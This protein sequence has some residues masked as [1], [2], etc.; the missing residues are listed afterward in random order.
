VRPPLNRRQVLRLGATIGLTALPGRAAP[1]AVPTGG[2][3]TEMARLAR[4]FL[5]EQGLPGL[6]VAFGREG[7][8]LHADG[9]G[10]ADAAGKV[11]V[12]PDH[13]F[14]IASVSK[15]ITATAI[16]VCVQQGRLKLD[17]PV[18]GPRGVLDFPATEALHG[19]TVDHLLTHT[20]GGWPNDGTD[21]MFRDPKLTHA[22]LIPW[23]LANLKPTHAPGEKY[24]YSNFGYCLLGRV[25]EKVTGQPYAEAVARLVLAP[26]GITGMHL[27]GNA[28]A[29]RRVN[30]VE[31]LTSRPDEAYGLNVT[32]MDAH[33]G[34][35][36]TASDLVLFASQLPRLLNPETLR[37]MTTPGRN[38]GYARGWSV[39]R[40]PNWWHNG[41]LPGTTSILVRTAGGLCWAGLVNGRTEKSGEALDRLMWRFKDVMKAWAD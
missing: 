41:S 6:S 36:A 20:S 15:P 19:I 18:F 5:R 25:L 14:R 32:R 11:P 33:G 3:Q 30:E 26:C 9:L 39:N 16:M 17:A 35:I 7:N 29:D 28:R 1:A 23:V 27:G 13:L 34:W 8:I 37:L 38:P 12:T 10:F 2:E 40:V 21:P 31:Y 22:E 24:A 4:A